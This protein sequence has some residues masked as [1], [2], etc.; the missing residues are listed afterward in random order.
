F[1]PPAGRGRVLITSQSHRWPS[2][3]RLEVPVLDLESATGFLVDRSG[4]Q[5]WR[6]AQDLA[7]EL[8]GLPLALELAAAYVQVTEA[9]LAGYLELL[10]QRADLLDGGE[11]DNAPQTVAAAWGLAF[12]RLERSAPKAAALLRLLAFCA[13][14]AVPLHLLLQPHPGLTKGLH[15]RV[16]RV[17]KRLLG[18]PRAATDAVAAL[19]RYSLIT[20]AAGELV[21][22]HPLVQVLTAEQIP[23][24][25]ASAWQQATAAII[26]A[27]VP[28]DPQR[29]DTWPEFAALVPHAQAVLPADGPGMERIADYLGFSG[30]YAASQEI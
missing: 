19:R 28:T 26:E 24:E 17:L 23:A 13:P 3:Q 25:P 16:A 21:S 27:A 29:P 22:V 12:K 15:R 18:D 6:A 7:G 5:D 4:D 10:R 2:G 11:P 14:A 30:S 1:V 8:G 20:P 9:D